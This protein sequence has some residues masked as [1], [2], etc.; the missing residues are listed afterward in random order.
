MSTKPGVTAR[1]RASI[2]VV[3]FP[4]ASPSAATRPSRMPT[5]PATPG[6]PVPSMIVP[7]VIF[8]SKSMARPYHSSAGREQA[9]SHRHPD[10]RLLVMRA[11]IQRDVERPPRHGRVGGPAAAPWP[12]AGDT[13]LASHFV[14][15]DRHRVH[16]VDEG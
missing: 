7:P 12:I 4:G 11:T 10:D 6:R 16:Y 14:D 9:L 13:P 8:R 2:V 15:V 3:A 1:P 5:S